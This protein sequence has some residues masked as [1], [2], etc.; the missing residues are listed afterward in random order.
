MEVGASVTGSGP[1]GFPTVSSGKASR[2]ELDA[3][4]HCLTERSAS[5]PPELGKWRAGRAAGTYSCVSP[6]TESQ[7]RD[8]GPG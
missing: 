3:L 7:P 2:A 6:E 1:R 8:G 5:C 4:R